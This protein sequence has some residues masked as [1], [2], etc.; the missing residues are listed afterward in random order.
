MIKTM[1]SLRQ[2]ILFSTTSLVLV[3]GVLITVLVNGMLSSTLHKD[4][5]NRGS[6]LARHLAQSS[7]NRLL[8]E[9]F[10]DLQL[11]MKDLMKFQE[12]VAYIFIVD[13][14]NNVV[15]HTFENGF[16]LELA[17]ANRAIAGQQYTAKML[18]TQGGNILDIAVPTPELNLGTIRLGISEKKILH[19]VSRVVNSIMSIT[20]A[21]LVIGV[22]VALLIAK[23]M[24]APLGE[25]VAA[26]EAI[27]NGDLTTKAHVTTCDEIGRLSEVI[28]SMTD[29]LAT[30]L[31]SRAK[32]E[33]ANKF[34][35][36][37][38][39]SMSDSISI[40]EV[41]TRRILAVNSVFLNEV[42]M[43]EE[44]VIGRRCFE[45][46]HSRNDVCEPPDDLCPLDEVLKTRTHKMVEHVH[47]DKDNMPYYVEV[48]VHPIMDN[49]G[50]IIQI[51]HATRDITERKQIENR[52]HETQKALLQKHDELTTLFLRVETAKRE[53]ERTMDC[54]GDILILADREK[55]IVRCNNA[56]REFKGTAYTGI[57]GKNWE[58][59]FV[60]AKLDACWADQGG[61]EVFHED[62]KRWFSVK[63]YP[64]S[65]PTSVGVVGHVVTIHDSTELKTLTKSLEITNAAIENERKSLQDTLDHLSL[66]IQRVMDDKDLRIRFKNPG[67]KKCYEL[68]HCERSDCSCY[69]KE[70]MRCWQVAGTYCGKNA[71]GKFV[72]KYDNCNECPVYQEATPE[73]TFQIGEHFNNMM[74]ILEEKNKELESAYSE[75]KSAQAQILQQEKMASIGQ[76]A[77]GVAHEINNPVGFIM[78]N[79]GSLKK[80]IGRFAEF[81]RAQSETITETATASPEIIGRVN[82]LRKSLKIDYF[83]EDSISL[84]SE[85]TDGAERVKKIVQ[86]LKSFSRVDEAEWKLADINTGIESTLNIVWNEIK[87]KATANKE[88]GDIPMIR[89]NPG[90]LNQV[91]MNM[92]VNAA[93]AIEKQG[94]IT[95]RTW[96]DND[97]ICV[98]IADTGKGIAP[99]TIKRIFE[100]FFTTKDVGKGTGLGLSIAY[101]IVKKHKGTIDVKSEVG[102]GTTFTVRIPAIEELNSREGE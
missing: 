61:A 67:L 51:V 36:T 101:D 75:L 42:R 64:Y 89:C 26:A 81:I 46:T 69:G 28:N 102:K 86:D 78:S 23:K 87:Y 32:M 3:L 57:L 58:E 52:Y 99:A 31:V 33:D 91:F 12:E 14:S 34:M 97:Y 30:T 6:V 93:H 84:I 79:L 70:A 20:L 7:G 95:I 2:K 74:H 41:D 1:L 56:L 54:V 15:V 55:K 50:K 19:D 90:Q 9:R 76:L 66:L 40:I 77:A 80:Y 10:V 62:T 27:G 65:D 60:G 4:L 85:S 59:V 22:L 38:L 17:K 25:L 11:D 44:D 18:A 63:A 47:Y 13:S 5:E 45:V 43:R 16:P 73:S 37:I 71:H 8:T 68:L 82:S 48:T 21:V 92:M 49:T 98:S 72:E 53:W 83:L 96:K 94:E 29:N 24:T 39:D 100:P 35:R 88:L